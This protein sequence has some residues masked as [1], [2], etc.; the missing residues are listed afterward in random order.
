MCR[1]PFCIPR[2]RRARVRRKAIPLPAWLRENADGA[3]V[4]FERVDD[5]GRAHVTREDGTQVLELR[6]LLATTSVRDADGC[7]APSLM[8]DFDV[9][10]RE[11]RDEGMVAENEI[12]K[13]DDIQRSCV[14]DLK[15][16]VEGPNVSQRVCHDM[17]SDM[18]AP[19]TL[20]RLE[21]CDSL[22]HVHAKK[23]RI[24]VS[25]PV[26]RNRAIGVIVPLSAIYWIPAYRECVWKVF[27]TPEERMHARDA[28]R[29]RREARSC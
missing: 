5:T 12:W 13:C 11:R 21:R 29:R 24:V 26:L 23:V 1:C 7:P 16:I 17:F 27:G 22:D 2:H 10:S 6:H 25:S 28:L 4:H 9:R 15:S 18:N 14:D 19:P 3:L 8:F 20:H